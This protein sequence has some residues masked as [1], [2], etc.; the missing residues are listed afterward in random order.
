[1][2]PITL[3][4]NRARPEAAVSVDSETDTPAVATSRHCVCP[5]KDLRGSRR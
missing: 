3:A 2:S 1:M 5:R 4:E